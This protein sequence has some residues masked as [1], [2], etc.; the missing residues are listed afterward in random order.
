MVLVMLKSVETRFVSSHAMTERVILHNKVY[1]VLTTDE[2][3]LG[4]IHKQTKPISKEVQ[5]PVCTT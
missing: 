4:W 5:T 2:Q 1:K 3:F